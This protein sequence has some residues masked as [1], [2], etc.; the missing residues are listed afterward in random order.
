MLH[1]RET[2]SKAIIIVLPSA[3]Y[4]S[5]QLKK[6]LR[7]L[8]NKAHEYGKL[9]IEVLLVLR[10]PGREGGYLYTISENFVERIA[11]VVSY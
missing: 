4:R 5:K 9:G 7:R 8:E 2:L 3:R 11:Q 1:S 10:F 6:Q